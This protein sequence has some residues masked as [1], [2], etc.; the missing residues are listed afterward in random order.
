MSFFHETFESIVVPKKKDQRDLA[1]GIGPEA[2]PGVGAAVF[3]AGRL[4]LDPST[5]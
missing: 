1:S 3:T 4:E 2:D 5:M